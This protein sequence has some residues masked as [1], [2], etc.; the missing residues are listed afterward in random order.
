MSKYSAN[1]HIHGW[2]NKD[3]FSPPKWHFRM[4]CNMYP[5][6]L[7][8]KFCLLSI[9]KCGGTF[10]FCF[11]FIC[12]HINRNAS[13]GFY[14]SCISVLAEVYVYGYISVSVHVHIYVRKIQNWR[15][16][17]RFSL[18]KM[19]CSWLGILLFITFINIFNVL[20]LYLYKQ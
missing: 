2:T 16:W 14:M 10:G 20:F 1:F 9:F 12:G 19:A 3:T 15:I 13:P 17:N 6:T 8:R 4:R 5:L 11:A 7:K 18:Y